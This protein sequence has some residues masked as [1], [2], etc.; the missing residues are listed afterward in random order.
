MDLGNGFILM[1][2]I[3]T[4]SIQHYMWS[5]GA[6]GTENGVKETQGDDSPQP[7]ELLVNPK[8]LGMTRENI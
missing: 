3:I 4:T 1:T 2:Q 8:V 5:H 7:L 6:R